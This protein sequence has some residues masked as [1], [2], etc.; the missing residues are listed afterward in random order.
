M[1]MFDDI[2]EELGRDK[3]NSVKSE[4][5]VGKCLLLKEGLNS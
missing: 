2:P 1:G 5:S 3:G 4:A